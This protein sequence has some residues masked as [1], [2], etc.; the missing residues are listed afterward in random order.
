MPG[1]THAKTIP[2][3]SQPAVHEMGHVLS[4]SG[5]IPREKEKNKRQ[6]DTDLPDIVEGTALVERNGKRT[7]GKRKVISYA[8]TYF[9]VLVL[10]IAPP[11]L[12]QPN[13]LDVVSMSS[14]G[15]ENA[16]TPNSPLSEQCSE[17]LENSDSDEPLEALPADRLKELAATKHCPSFSDT[18]VSKKT[19]RSAAKE[20]PLS[21]PGEPKNAHSAIETEINKTEISFQV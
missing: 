10:D 5:A 1:A 7:R 18:A 2:L 9:P 21:V 6:H 17:S 15:F 14:R 20:Q 4:S 11:Q 8:T 19:Q 3:I 12:S 13:Q 16:H